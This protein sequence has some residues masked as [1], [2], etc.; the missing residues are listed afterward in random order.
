MITRKVWTFFFLL[1]APLFL[2][3]PMAAQQQN[4]PPSQAQGQGQGGMAGMDMSKPGSM[5]HDTMANP[6]AARSA[7]ES[8]S[9]E[10][11]EM[12]AHMFMTALRP[13]NA[14]DEK[15]AE[16]I[17]ATL[18]QSIVKYQDYK[19]ALADGYQIF[20]PNV[21]L[22]QYHFTN[23]RYAFEAAFAFNP[24]H[25]TSL[26]YKKVPG[27]YTLLGAMFTAPKN[28]TGDQLNDRVP[29]SVARWHKH[30]NLCM[31]QKGS[32]WQ[33]VNWK[34]FGLGGSIATVDACEE[35]GGRRV[36]QVFGWM[37]HVYPFEKDPN[38]IW[39]H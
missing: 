34:Q 32:S 27:G 4:Q 18:R 15:R 1:I 38:K 21:P 22:P 3:S 28:F 6:D 17:A 29:L 31:P 10:H 19:V 39:T 9:H 36:P 23:W 16:Q 7:N 20:M 25:P 33:Q 24:E 37:V 26:L 11:M 2:L 8:M 5:D 13:A 30:I 12:N 14:D 35:A